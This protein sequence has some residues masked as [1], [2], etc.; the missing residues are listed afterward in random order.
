VS[1]DD[2]LNIPESADSSIKKQHRD[3]YVPVPDMMVAN[4]VNANKLSNK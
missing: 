3:K 4:L 1:Y 2:W